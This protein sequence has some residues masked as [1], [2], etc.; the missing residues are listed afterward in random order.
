[1]MFQVLIANECFIIH[2]NIDGLQKHQRFTKMAFKIILLLNS[3][4]D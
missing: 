3:S 4:F 2:L 1:M